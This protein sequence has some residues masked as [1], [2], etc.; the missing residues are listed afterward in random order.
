MGDHGCAFLC[1]PTA[2]LNEMRGL[3]PRR[4]SSENVVKFTKSAVASLAV[5]PG[6]S[7]RIVWDADLHSFGIRIRASGNRAWVIRPPRSGGQSRLH[8][9]GSVDAID[10]INELAAH[11][12][13]AA[14]QVVGNRLPLRVQA[15]TA[16]ALTLGRDPAVDDELALGHD[17]LAPLRLNR[18]SM[19]V[20]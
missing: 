4:A 9:I 13:G 8:T 6:Q 2:P 12:P 1:T 10:I 20:L 5:L 19:T 14:V 17:R 16:V 15:E 3:M 18:R 11:G 7:E